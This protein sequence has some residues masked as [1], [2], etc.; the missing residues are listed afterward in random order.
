MR[1]MVEFDIP[2]EE[3]EAEGITTRAQLEPLFAADLQSLLYDR[4][5]LD[6]DKPSRDALAGQFTIV[7]VEGML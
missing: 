1:I 2:D 3:Y 5:G 4:A 6:G 7:S